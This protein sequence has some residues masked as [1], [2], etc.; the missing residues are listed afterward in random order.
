MTEEQIKAVKIVVEM[1]D[2]KMQEAPSREIADVC[3]YL[4]DLLE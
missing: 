3:N 2:E 4:S 1:L